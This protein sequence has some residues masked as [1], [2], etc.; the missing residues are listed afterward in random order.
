MR[1]KIGSG[2]ES[3]EESMEE[4]TE[5]RDLSGATTDDLD[6]RLNRLDTDWVKNGPCQFFFT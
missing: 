1:G 5:R 4:R 2:I 6:D 3:K